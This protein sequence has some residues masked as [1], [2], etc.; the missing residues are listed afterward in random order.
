MAVDRVELVPVGEDVLEAIQRPDGVWVS[1]RRVCEA[2][3]IDGKNQREKLKQKAW[4]RE[5]LITSH[6]SSGRM[7]Q[8]HCLHLDCLPMWL[9]TLERVRPEVQAK[10][11]RFQ[12]EARDVL[13]QH[14]LG[15]PKQPPATQSGGVLGLARA[16]LEGLEDHERRIEAEHQARL[17]LAERVARVERQG[18]LARESKRRIRAAIQTVT[19]ESQ[20]WCAATGTSFQA[21]FSSMRSDLGLKRTKDGGPSLGE[22]DLRADQVLRAARFATLAGVP[23]CG[24][25]AIAA[26]L[27]G[28]DDQHAE[29]AGGVQ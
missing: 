14:F 13:A 6:D 23:G 21:F 29:V 8:V 4:A 10:L 1:I 28:E 15:T 20:R 16:L 22:A 7:Q 27:N 5:V 26:I 25:E 3:G 18:F 24:A 12:R 9:A 11:A 17:E 19:R 2:L